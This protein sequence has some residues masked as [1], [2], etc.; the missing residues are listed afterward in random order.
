[1]NE[2]KLYL[3]TSALLPFY[4]EEPLSDQVQH[5]LSGLRSPVFISDLTKVEIASA[6][7]RWVRT[8]EIDEA[9]GILLE[10][11]FADDIDRGL[12]VVRPF[13]A[14]HYRHA[15]K[16]LAART[17]PI[18]SLDALHLACCHLL[19]LRLVTCDHIMHR[20]AQQFGVASI[21]LTAEQR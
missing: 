16:C 15:E 14:R 4:R 9:Q 12:F 20:S 19:S 18:R 8:T 2:A 3:D 17:T 5:V 6:I 21:L 10:T 7:A 13:T 11:T 1:M